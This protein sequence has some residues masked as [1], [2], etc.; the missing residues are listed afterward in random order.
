M[1]T[2]DWAQDQY[3]N[4]L[5]YNS[6]KDDNHLTFNSYSYGISSTNP[7][8]ETRYY[9]CRLKD[10]KAKLNIVKGDLKLKGTH[11]CTPR[12]IINGVT[13]LNVQKDMEAQIR[14][15]AIIS[16]S[17]TAEAIYRL[18]TDK[19]PNEALHNGFTV[20]EITNMVYNERQKHRQDPIAKLETPGLTYL[21][22]NDK[23]PFMIF[24][25]YYYHDKSKSYQKNIGFGHPELLMKLKAKQICL[26]MDAT[27]KC[28]PKDYAQTFIIIVYDE[29][30]KV[31]SPALFV[32]MT[33]KHVES[34]IQLF[35]QLQLYLGVPLDVS[36]IT[37]DFEASEMAAV[38]GIYIFN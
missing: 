25:Q 21:S 1:E 14:N 33:N 18:V 5:C 3:R 15:L 8:K 35:R 16:Y 24:H 6:I 27:F 32:L 12:T 4:L 36:S 34:Y 20:K 28:T 7:I 30:L 26:F 31:Y 19:M 29:I 17:A 37:A 11:T 9:K 10:C 23:R 38:K 2:I 13:F 22:E